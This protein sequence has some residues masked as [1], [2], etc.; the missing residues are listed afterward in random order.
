MQDQIPPAPGR[1]IEIRF[2]FWDELRI[3]P[4]IQQSDSAVLTRCDPLTYIQCEQRMIAILCAIA[5][6]GVG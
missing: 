1:K 6:G 5:G 4:R 2:V 3:L